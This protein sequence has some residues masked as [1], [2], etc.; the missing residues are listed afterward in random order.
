MSTKI[1]L[2][3]EQ[4]Q[5][6]VSNDILPLEEVQYHA[7]YN[8]FA[9]ERQYSEQPESINDIHGLE[10]DDSNVIPDSSNMC[11]NDN[12]VDQNDAEYLDERVALANLIAN[13]TLDTKQNKKILKQLKKANASLTQELKEC[14]SN[15]EE[16]TRALGE[17]ISYRDSCLIALQT[18]QTELEK[19]IALND[20]TIDY[21]KLQSKLNDTLGLLAQKDN[22]IKEGLKLKAYEISVVK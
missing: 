16:T 18:K 5:Q 22:D 13:L 9:N 3:L 15:L 1:E 4:S 10:K 12:Q 21:D 7:K 14:K 11:N 17:S 20:R 19:Y 8:V 2:T 6:D